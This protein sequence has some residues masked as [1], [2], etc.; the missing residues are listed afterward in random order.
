MP[1]FR[2]VLGISKGVTMAKIEE[3]LGEVHNVTIV[4]ESTTHFHVPDG[5]DVQVHPGAYH[6]SIAPDGHLALGAMQKPEQHGRILRA[7][8]I[9]HSFRLIAPLAVS[10]AAEHDSLHIVLLLPGGGA[11]QSTG[12]LRPAAR[13][14]DTPTF[15]TPHDLAHAIITR[16]PGPLPKY[17]HPFNAATVMAVPRIRREARPPQPGRS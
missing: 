17:V 1:A 9:W 2:A 3:P 6:V 10:I 4:L 15:A 7:F 11:L 8:K 16:F 14:A 12:S 5:S 13:R